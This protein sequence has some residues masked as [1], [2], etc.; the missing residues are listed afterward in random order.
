MGALRVIACL[1][2]AA[3]HIAKAQSVDSN[4]NT[5]SRPCSAFPGGA[6]TIVRHYGDMPYAGGTFENNGDAQTSLTLLR[7]A[8][9]DSTKTYSLMVKKKIKMPSSPVSSNQRRMPNQTGI[10][11]G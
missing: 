4:S 2:G 3:L 10:G 6:E 5:A 1:P 7:N 9:L 8:N 11:L